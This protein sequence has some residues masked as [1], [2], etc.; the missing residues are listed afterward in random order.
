M[1]STGI[2]YPEIWKTER[3]TLIAIALEKKANPGFSTN[4]GSVDIL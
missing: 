4:F 2:P 3:K 1:E